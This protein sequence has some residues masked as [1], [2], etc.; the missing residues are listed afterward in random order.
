MRGNGPPF[1]A[2]LYPGV[3]TSFYSDRQV[4]VNKKVP[5]EATSGAAKI[6][7]MYFAA[8]FIDKLVPAVG[9]EPTTY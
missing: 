2:P 4:P 7:V 9:F 1:G 6:Q 3:V 5:D 8:E